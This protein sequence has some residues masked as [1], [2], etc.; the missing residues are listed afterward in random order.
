MNQH[1]KNDMINALTG[2]RKC[3]VWAV[4]IAERNGDHG[5]EE[6]LFLLNIELIRILESYLPSD[7]GLR[8]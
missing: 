5:G 2:A 4:D 3:L 8:A 6:D 7:R 1:A